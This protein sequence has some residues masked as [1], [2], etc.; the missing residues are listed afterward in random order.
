MT[1]EKQKPDWSEERWREMLVKQRELMW[2]DDMIERLA[3]WFGLRNGMKVIDVG[4]GLGYLGYTYWPFFGRG[5]EYIGVDTSQK[6]LESASTAAC[7]WALGGKADFVEGNAYSLPFE[8][9]SADVVICQTLLMHLE[10]PRGALAEMVR[11]AKPGGLISCHEPDNLSTA[12]AKGDRSIPEFDIDD[13]LFVSKVD[14]LCNKGRIKLGRGDHSMGSKV[15]RMMSELGLI[16]IEARM[17]DRV[18]LLLPPYE[19]DAQ[20][21]LLQQ[22]KDNWLDDD[23]KAYWMERGKEEFFAGGGSPQEWER[24][25]KIVDYVKPIY[26]QQL[27]DGE[28]YLCGGMFF[29]IS[30][31]RKPEVGS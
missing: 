22:V 4:C 17:N 12:L 19:D 18:Q 28:F 23:K 13:L 27:N 24:C 9:D 1:D 30:K 16:D 10:N 15:P 21:K 25:L 14:I 29:Y 11:V 3:K 2:H 20:Q 7:N 8:N 31:G 26:K 5:G 6:L